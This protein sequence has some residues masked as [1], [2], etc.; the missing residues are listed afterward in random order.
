MVDDQSPPIWE[1]SRPWVCDGGVYQFS[2]EV[3]NER[4]ATRYFWDL[5]PVQQA[6]QDNIVQFDELPRLDREKFRLVGLGDD[7]VDEETPLDVGMTFVYANADRNQ[8]ALVPTPDRP[9]IEWKTGSRARFSI[10]DSN[11]K[12]A[13]LKTY[14]Y[15]AHQLA[16]T[17][18]AYGQQLRTRYTFELSGLSDA[19]RNLVEKSI[20]RYGYNIE[21]GGTPS[22]AF[23][24]LIEIFQQHE[25]VV[26]GKEGVTG[27]YLTTYDGQVYWVELVN[28]TTFGGEK[29]RR[30]SRIAGSH[31]S[32]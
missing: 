20:G 13:T 22:D 32:K 2:Y 9:V 8:S 10:T 18:E 1:D 19:E 14:Q 17:V 29:R 23:W 7:A 5:T 16:P 31:H 26:D 6:D 12:N 4:P 15:T 25:A 21:R 27:D 3:R 28:G 30:S 24:S 11:S